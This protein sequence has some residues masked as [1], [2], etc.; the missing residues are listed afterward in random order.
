MND[1]PQNPD[2]QIERFKD[3]IQKKWN[4]VAELEKDIPVF[5]D[6]SPLPRKGYVYVFNLSQPPAGHPAAKRCFAWI[7]RSFNSDWSDRILG[8]NDKG[9]ITVLDVQVPCDDDLHMSRMAV[10]AWRTGNLV[11]EKEADYVESKKWQWD[12]LHN[13]R[14][15]FNFNNEIKAGNFFVR[16]RA[17]GKISVLIV[18]DGDFV[19]EGIQVKKL[20][21]VSF[22]LTQRDIDE[23]IKSSPPNSNVFSFRRIS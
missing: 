22:G 11:N 21:L 16:K 9:D 6:L 8:H 20:S 3:T 5:C 23:G 15:E 17:D 12:E 14:V 1:S 13:Q 10:W 7:G 18:H 4:C 19:I 2:P